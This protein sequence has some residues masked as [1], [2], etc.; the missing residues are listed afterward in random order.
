MPTNLAH[1]LLYIEIGL[2]LSMIYQKEENL[3]V[4]HYMSYESF[5]LGA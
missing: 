3:S 5:T 1:L 2:A 4:A